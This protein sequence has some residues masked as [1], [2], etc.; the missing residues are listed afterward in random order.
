MF[1][2]KV[3]KEIGRVLKAGGRMAISDIVTEKELSE[4]IVCDATL[5]G[6]Q[7]NNL[8][9]IKTTINIPLTEHLVCFIIKV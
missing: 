4:S 8:M 6:I 9:I 5:W 1:Q 7:V 3:F 2:E